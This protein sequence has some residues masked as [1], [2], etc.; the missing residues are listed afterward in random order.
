MEKKTPEQGKKALWTRDFTIF[1]V[2]SVVS[3]LG[4]TL[5]SFA[6]D[7]MVLDHTGSTLLFAI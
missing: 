2:G 6:M 4:T 7:L 3:I 5:S 1:T